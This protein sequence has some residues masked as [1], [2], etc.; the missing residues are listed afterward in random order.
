[1]NSTF[2]APFTVFFE[3][4]LLSY[5]LLVLARKVVDALTVTAGKFE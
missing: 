1:M 2:L 5:E 3:L 4:N